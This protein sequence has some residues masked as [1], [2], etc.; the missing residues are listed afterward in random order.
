LHIIKVTE[1]IPT[2]FAQLG[3]PHMPYGWSESII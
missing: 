3:L 1:S 2:N